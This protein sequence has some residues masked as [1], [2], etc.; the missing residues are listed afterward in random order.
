MMSPSVE[1]NDMIHS[2]NTIDSTTTNTSKKHQIRSTVETNLSLTSV[3]PISSRSSVF[4]I[5]QL[6]NNGKHVSSGRQLQNL[7]T[8]EFQELEKSESKQSANNNNNF[9]G[10]SNQIIL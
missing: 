4:C 9:S 7:P 5:D 8:H 6:L 3:H 2:I 10:N 1:S